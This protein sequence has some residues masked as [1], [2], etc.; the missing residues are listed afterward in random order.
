MA[1]IRVSTTVDEA[2]LEEAR[3]LRSESN[4]AALLDEA[5]AALLARYQAAQIDAAY[6]SYDTTPIDEPDEWGDLASFR[7]AA[8]SS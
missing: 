1:R 3:R 4:D 6:T 2:L 7:E 8:G 5:L